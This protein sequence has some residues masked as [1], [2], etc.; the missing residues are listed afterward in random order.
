MTKH[1]VAACLAA[2]CLPLAALAATPFD[3]TW[4]MDPASIHAPKPQIYL[5]KDGAYTC[6]T[7]APAF[8][9]PADGAPHPVA[10]NPYFDAAAIKV[11]D[12]RTIQETDSKN[13][14][15]VATSTDTVSPDGKTLSFTFTDSSDTSAAPVAG[16]GTAT[17]VGAAPAGAH[18]ISGAWRL[19]NLG[20]Y[21]ENG[22]L[23]TYKI[24]GDT[25]SMSTPTG[26][27][28]S[29]K[30]DGTDS[31]YKGDPGTTSVSVIKIGGST[32]QETDKRNGKVIGIVKMTVSK[33][34][35]TMKTTYT[36]KL[37]GATST[38]TA[39]KQ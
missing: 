13:G 3:G 39:T 2:T 16:T 8:T 1:L 24:D 14:K 21:S 4:K 30:L 33:D 26:Q 29:A 12:P 32:I 17:R 10:G 34:G 9:V 31:P 20:D 27:S 36:D 6:K 37:R 7:C 5:L 38:S 28:Y 18:A 23:F 19:A 11:V 25:L 35:K 15:L 22:L